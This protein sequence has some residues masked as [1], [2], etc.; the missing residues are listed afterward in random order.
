MKFAQE[1]VAG[2][3]VAAANQKVWLYAE[4]GKTLVTSATTNANG[5]V[6]FGLQP[7]HFAIAYKVGNQFIYQGISANPGEFKVISPFDETVELDSDLPT[8]GCQVSKAIQINAVNGDNFE[9]RTNHPEWIS[10]LGEDGKTL[11]ICAARA[12]IDGKFDLWLTSSAGYQQVEDVSWQGT[13]NLTFSPQ[14]TT[15]REWSLNLGTSTLFAANVVIS[16]PEQL[17]IYSSVT[18]NLESWDKLDVPRLNDSSYS[19]VFFGRDYKSIGYKVAHTFTS[20]SAIPSINLPAASIE[21]LTWNATQQTVTWDTNPSSTVDFFE[22]SVQLSGTRLS[23]VTMVD[24]NQTSFTVPQLPQELGGSPDDHSTV[25]LAS[26]DFQSYNN[27]NDWLSATQTPLITLHEFIEKLRD[28]EK[29]ATRI[30]VS[31]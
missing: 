10:T 24:K 2:L 18:Y 16:N 17:A 13:T 27:L 15:L 22:L 9:A 19:L 26:V 25:E 5:W 11:T 30:T 8:G 12:P 1:N 29:S 7:E 31:K 6:D 21:Q 4:D 3:E 28:A 23:L 20:L 14:A